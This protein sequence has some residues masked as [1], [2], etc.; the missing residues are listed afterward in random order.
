[1]SKQVYNLLS[2]YIKVLTFP[3]CYTLKEKIRCKR[4][5]MKTLFLFSSFLL[6]FSFIEKSSCE[7]YKKV[8][9]AK[10]NHHHFVLSRS[11]DMFFQDLTYYY[12]IWSP[13]HCL[14]KCKEYGNACSHFTY[15]YSSHTCYIK[16]GRVSFDQAFY[17]TTVACGINCHVIKSEE[18]HQVLN[19]HFW[20]PKFNDGY[21]LGFYRGKDCYFEKEIGFVI[22]KNTTLRDC[23]LECRVRSI[24]THFQYLSGNCELFRDSFD[25]KEIKKC[26]NPFC[27][28]GYDC[29][30]LATEEICKN[31]KKF[32]IEIIPEF[33]K[34]P[35]PIYLEDFLFFAPLNTTQSKQTTKIGAV[36]ENV[37]TIKNKEISSFLHMGKSKI[38]I[39]DK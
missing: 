31:P 7:T 19:D 27:H 5:K 18:C 39:P 6:L 25:L 12:Y 33:D 14:E 10:S 26:N 23:V 15:H 36:R 21:P 30:A 8:E 29:S 34:T 35:E 13:E 32:K 3:I 16:T 11:C 37:K 9:F 38:I 28:C 4:S 17:R 20:L 24:C 22:L 1:M 2:A